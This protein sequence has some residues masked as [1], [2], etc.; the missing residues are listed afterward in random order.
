MWLFLFDVK[1]PSVRAKPMSP[2]A[3]ESR[4][5]IL[6]NHQSVFSGGTPVNIEATHSWSMMEQIRWIHVDPQGKLDYS[7]PKHERNHILEDRNSSN[8]Q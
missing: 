7:Q 1:L 8:S 3:T 5:M 4:M 2:K 6:R